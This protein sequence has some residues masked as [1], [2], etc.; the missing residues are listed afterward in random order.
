M[1]AHALFIVSIQKVCLHFY[2]LGTGE[3][4]YS[5][6]DKRRV[7]SVELLKS[8][9]HSTD[10]SEQCELEM[11]PFINYFHRAFLSRAHVRITLWLHV[12]CLL[13]GVWTISSVD[14][15]LVWYVCLCQ[16]EMEQVN[17]HVCLI[18]LLC[19]VFAWVMGTFWPHLYQSLTMGALHEM[20]SP[21]PCQHWPVWNEVTTSAVHCP[22]LGVW[23]LRNSTRLKF[24]HGVGGS[25]SHPLQT[26]C[27]TW[28][29]PTFR[30]GLEATDRNCHCREWTR[31]PQSS[32]WC[33]M[34]LDCWEVANLEIVFTEK[35]TN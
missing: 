4:W 14:S 1:L 21:C 30:G 25:A 7:G 33:R 26:S 20:D 23:P 29:P 31:R 19:W 8:W 35:N 22:S 10:K 12:V 13:L 3:F 17:I 18:L 11:L 9:G 16:F 24:T 34:G 2:S 27:D 15:I 5:F 32:L 28:R 6:P